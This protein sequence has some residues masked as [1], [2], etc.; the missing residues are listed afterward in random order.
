MKTSKRALTTELKQ[1]AVKI[2]LI[3]AAWRTRGVLDSEYEDRN[4]IF[5]RRAEIARI[6]N[7]NPAPR[8]DSLIS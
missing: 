2:E 8:T 7:P 3:E 1:I 4:K 6:L 5:A